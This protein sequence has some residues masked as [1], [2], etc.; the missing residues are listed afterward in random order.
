MV[1]KEV[2]SMKDILKNPRI[3]IWILCVVA[4]FL[5]IA[6]NINPQGVIVTYVQKNAS[7]PLS[8]NDVIY[9]INN[10][11]ATTDLAQQIF[12][13]VVKLDTNKGVKYA[14]LNGTTLGVDVDNVQPTNL[15]FGLDI[16]GGVHA[17]I[18]PNTTDNTTLDQIVST[19]QTRINVYGLREALFRTTY[20]DNQGFVEI[21]IAGGSEAELRELLEKQGMFVGK[22]PILVRTTNNV[23]TLKFDK[24][25]TLTI[26]NDSTISFNGNSYNYGDAFTIAGVEL[27][28]GGVADGKINLTALV[29][30]GN[31]IKTVYFDPQRSTIT[32]QSD[33]SYRWSFGVQLS[34]DSAQRFA[35]VTSNIPIVP[36]V[37]GESY[38]ESK[39]YMYLDNNLIDSLNIVSTLKGRV[40]TEISITGGSTS[41]DQAK[42][43]KMRLQSILRSG[44]LPTSISIVKLDTISPNLGSGF[45]TNAGLAGL[46]AIIGVIIIVSIR[47]R[48]PKYV[49][50]M[51]LISISEVLM[52]LGVAV[53]I[54]WT[55]DL[56]A[57]A[58][59][60]ASVGTGIDSQIIILDQTLRGERLD[61]SFKE[62][63]KR[64]FFVVF[65]SAGTV[66]AA[67][68]PLMT[69][70]F[71]TLRGFAIT[72]I[73]GV[74]IGVF[75]ARP[76]YGVIV[77]K[78]HNS[79]VVQ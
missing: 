72:T 38:L 67:M 73:L 59:I 1:R 76:A 65:G 50:P 78:M 46:G 51:S 74:L 45:L 2:G 23:G 60:I 47:Y 34:P 33:S 55:I 36:G 40:E 54:N 56:P 7:S 3:I 11:V 21:S 63:L 17:V 61:I 77:E 75:I 39:I 20:Y 43:D 25:Y 57:I 12:F 53:L 79:H 48:K 5:I 68:L 62:K 70:G 30:N 41:M 27:T 22:V 14:N 66:I 71:G 64:A 52:I 69:I 16:K 35:W 13:G 15:K 9:K 28:Y 24:D 8:V 26:L 32:K 49:W 29:F 37:G 58:G 44:A 31:D 18:Q 19:L 42:S 6:P 4:S 10:N